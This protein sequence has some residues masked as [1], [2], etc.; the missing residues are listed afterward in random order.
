M[1]ETRS[2]LGSRMIRHDYVLSE[3]NEWEKHDHVLAEGD[4]WEE[5]GQ[6]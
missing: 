4:V 2:A 6:H 3:G 5:N 1:G